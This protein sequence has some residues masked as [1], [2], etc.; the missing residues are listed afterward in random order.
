MLLGEEGALH[1]LSEKM[2]WISLREGT[3]PARHSLY[4]CAYDEMDGGDGKIVISPGWFVRLVPP[5]PTPIPL[6]D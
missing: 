4:T 3:K 2:R 6:D 5:S 1:V